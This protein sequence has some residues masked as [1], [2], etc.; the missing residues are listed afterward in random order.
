[1][2]KKNRASVSAGRLPEKSGNDYLR[3]KPLVRALW[4]AMVVST[5][6][7]SAGIAG[8]AVSLPVPEAV[9]AT[10]GAANYLQD[11]S[12]GIINQQS[13]KAILNWKNF[14]IG[15][16]NSVEFIQPSSSSIALNRINEI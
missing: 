9:F 3:Q 14:N 16:D 11:G 10:Y 5:F 2:G 6:V 7:P 1:M 13:D 15:K 4:Y 8:S 12:R